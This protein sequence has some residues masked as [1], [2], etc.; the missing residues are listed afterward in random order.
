MTEIIETIIYKLRENRAALLATA[1]EPGNVQSL[2]DHRRI[3]KALLAKL[4]AH[5][6]SDLI[7]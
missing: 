6:F 4:K 2:L 1:V 7:K 5:I 3:E